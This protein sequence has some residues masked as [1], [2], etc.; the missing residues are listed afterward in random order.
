MNTFLPENYKIPETSNYM[1]L[2][3]GE[4]IFRIMSSA[5]VGWEYFTVENKPVRSKEEF[6]ETPS[7]IKKDGRINNFWAF[8]VWNYGT[9][10]LQ[11]L[12]VTQKTLQTPLKALADNPKWGNPR[13]YDITIIRVGKTKQDTSY[14]VIPNPKEELPEEITKLYEGSDIQLEKLY[15]NGNPFGE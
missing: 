4:H 11:I 5:I 6:E 2:S 10:K 1:K 12:E 13:A 7:D 8:V 14:S 9:N 15:E 3:E